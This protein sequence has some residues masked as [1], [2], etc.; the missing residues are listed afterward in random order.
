[1]LLY[2]IKCI[3]S[4]LANVQIFKRHKFYEFHRRERFHE[5]LVLNVK[6]LPLITIIK[7][8]ST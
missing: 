8:G 5:V 7:Y 6:I 3:K 2:N 4:V 1:M